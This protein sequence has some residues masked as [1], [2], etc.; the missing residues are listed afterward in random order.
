MQSDISDY[1]V[2]IEIILLSISFRWVCVHSV[3]YPVVPFIRAN[4]M[5]LEALGS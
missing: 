5:E 4:K 1:G 3:S 2:D